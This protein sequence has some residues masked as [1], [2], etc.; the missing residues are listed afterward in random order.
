M[1][2]TDDIANLAQRVQ[3]GDL[4]A[5][6]LLYERYASAMY[7]VSHRITNH[8]VSTEDILQEAFAKSFTKIS[9]LKDKKR[10]GGWLKKMVVNASIDYVKKNRN[11]ERLDTQYDLA[12]EVEEEAIPNVSMEQ[13]Q[14]AIAK[15]PE[16]C[17]MVFTLYLLEGYTHE[18][19][20]GMLGVA[21]STSKSQYR[22]ALK[23][24]RRDL[25]GLMKGVV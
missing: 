25:E 15:L 18:E 8:K 12:A 9:S 3:K 5:A 17:R 2:P 1:K 24:L 4:L 23:L 20:G 19:V 13:I 7:L 11:W 14:K 6:E 22:Y 16:K 21:T 10:Y